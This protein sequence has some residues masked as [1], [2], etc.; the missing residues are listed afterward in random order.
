MEQIIKKF[1][2]QIDETP[3][4][5]VIRLN[6]ENRCVLRICR[7]PKKLVYQKN[8][9]KDFIDITY[10]YNMGLWLKQSE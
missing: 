5:V 3:G 7:I 8:E 2:L 4:G 1:E 10:P 6:D 9:I